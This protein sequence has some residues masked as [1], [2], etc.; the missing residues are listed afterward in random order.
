MNIYQVRDGGGDRVLNIRYFW[1]EESRID[2]DWMDEHLR[3]R[4][5]FVSEDWKFASFKGKSYRVCELGI[6]DE[7]PPFIKVWDKDPFA[8]Y[9]P[10]YMQPLPEDDGAEYVI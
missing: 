3:E 9:L 4:V 2:G 1:I 6:D 8:D 10:E 7:D 5:L